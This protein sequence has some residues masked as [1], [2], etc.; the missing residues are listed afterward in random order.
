MF[1]CTALVLAL[2]VS[3]P[4]PQVQFSGCESAQVAEITRLL[5]V[6]LTGRP[7]LPLSD[8]AIM[9]S[10]SAIDLTVSEAGGERKREMGPA[11]SERT[12]ALAA[13][14]LIDALNAAATPSPAP[15]PP[16]PQ[17]DPHAPNRWLI[18]A[19][20]LAGMTHAPASATFGASL[21]A[22]VYPITALPQL[23]LHVDILADHS[24]R[25]LSAGEASLTRL[26]AGVA[27][28]ARTTGPQ[29]RATIGAGLRGGPLFVTGSHATANATAHHGT[30]FWLGP[31]LRFGVQWSVTEHVVLLAG[32]ES[33]LI[34]RSVGLQV[35]GQRQASLN[36]A[37]L[38]GTLGIGT[39]F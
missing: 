10:P 5:E 11:T 16:E 32:V 8:V 1:L 13:V 30:S 19:N 39:A 12:I 9:C 14:E 21:G 38:V 26:G 17:P 4:V 23:G 36:G 31:M 3:A 25:T 33:G 35:S 29:W 6:E 22:D 15:A 20:A 34:M 2:S 24:K 7:E 27:L 18:S 37:W 28:D